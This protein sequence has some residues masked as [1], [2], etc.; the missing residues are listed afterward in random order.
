MAFNGQICRD[1]H[2]HVYGVLGLVESGSG[3]HVDYSESALT[4]CT[5]VLEH[6]A[7]TRELSSTY[8]DRV[9]SSCNTLRRALVAKA[10]PSAIPITVARTYMTQE[11]VGILLPA[12]FEMPPTSSLPRRKPGLNM[13]LSTFANVISFEVWLICK[14][15]LPTPSYPTTQPLLSEDG[16]VNKGLRKLDEP[17]GYVKHSPHYYSVP[18]VHELQGLGIDY[19]IFSLFSRTE[20][21]C[22]YRW[23]GGPG[24]WVRDQSWH[25]SAWLSRGRRADEED[26]LPVPRNHNTN[27]ASTGQD[28]PAPYVM[29]LPKFEPKPTLSSN[30]DF[31]AFRN[32]NFGTQ[33]MRTGILPFRD[34]DPCFHPR[35]NK[36]LILLHDR[37]VSEA[38]EGASVAATTA[39]AT[40]TQASVPSKAEAPLL[41]RRS[42]VDLFVGRHVPSAAT[43][44]KDRA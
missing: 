35:C 29:L 9:I 5:R 40:K 15:A 30:T 6:D 36:R 32:L 2:D 17:P 20:T 26:R 28:Q 18:C 34:G 37:D 27:M 13:D 3:F 42:S 8:I 24:A 4:L 14:T 39:A 12:Q 11:P 44:S 7:T 41:R 21:A 10:P 25:S 1:F 19:A 43:Q 38:R 23:T 31:G 33:Y 22:T 16:G